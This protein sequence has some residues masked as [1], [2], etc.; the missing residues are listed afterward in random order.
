MPVGAQTRFDQTGVLYLA[1]EVTDSEVNDLLRTGLKLP[2]KTIVLV[3]QAKVNGQDMTFRMKV[4]ASDYASAA[5]AVFFGDRSMQNPGY[6]AFTLH[7]SVGVNGDNNLL[8]V[9]RVEQ[10]LKYLGFPAFNAPASFQGSIQG[11]SMPQTA[12]PGFFEQPDSNPRTSKEF[13][14]DGIFGAEEASA[15]RA[16]EAIKNQTT[17]DFVKGI[18]RVTGI[19]E[20]LPPRI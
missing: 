7:G 11:V 6:S 20:C 16:F 4:A 10:R 14:V 9:W 12:L 1:P 3:F 8:D 19:P 2:G 17:A 15:L 5:G 13:K 18:L